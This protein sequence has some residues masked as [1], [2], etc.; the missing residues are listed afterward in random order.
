MDLFCDAR[1]AKS[2]KLIYLQIDDLVILAPA[3]SA[4]PSLHIECN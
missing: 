2:P 3:P 4:P 1:E